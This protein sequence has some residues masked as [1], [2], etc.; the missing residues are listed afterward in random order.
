MNDRLRP[1]STRIDERPDGGPVPVVYIAG[2]GRSGSTV[3]NVILGSHPCIE[4]VGE[5]TNLVEQGWDQAHYCSCGERVPSCSFWK[6]VRREWAA[7]LGGDEDLERYSA[8]QHRFEPLRRRPWAA[9]S[10]GFRTAAFD[11]FSRRTAALFAAIRTVS[12]KPVV[13]DSSKNPLRALALEQMPG[14][15]LRVVHLVRD[16]RGVAQSLKR[17][18]GKDVR[19]GIQRDMP[20]RPVWRSALFWLLV[21]RLAD[22]LRRTVAPERSLLLRYE[23]LTAD[24]GEALRRVGDVVGLDVLPLI[25]ALAGEEALPTGHVVAGNRLRMARAVRLRLDEEWRRSLSARDQRIFSR[26][27]GADLRR[28]GYPGGKDLGAPGDDA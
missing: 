10:G 23:D 21:N 20:G 4:G 16:G 22:R 2:A 18:Y 1:V 3:L 7:R 17:S 8:L 14:I 13:A 27:A 28:Y 11:D 15:D 5:L 12:G 24:P 9:L 6:E 26:I 25:E 19:Q